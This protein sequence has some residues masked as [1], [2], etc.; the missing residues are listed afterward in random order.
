[1]T[2]IKRTINT[3]IIE[4]YLDYNE[5]FNPNYSFTNIILKKSLIDTLLKQIN[6]ELSGID[7]IAF[8]KQDFLFDDI[9]RNQSLKYHITLSYNTDSQTKKKTSPFTIT[10]QKTLQ[11]DT[12]YKDF[13]KAL[14]F[15]PSNTPNKYFLSINLKDCE[16]LLEH[17]N[18]D[19]LHISIAHFYS[20]LPLNELNESLKGMS[21]SGSIS[22][23]LKGI[24]HD[25]LN[26]L[27]ENNMCLNVFEY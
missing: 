5:T 15:R 7:S 6:H 13:S 22:E 3:K 20:S 8:I 23:S 12:D 9:D 4:R 1:M 16:E 21:Y 10:L 18:S 2:D 11:I 14:L 26:Y 25:I 24:D 17:Y 19:D 27:T